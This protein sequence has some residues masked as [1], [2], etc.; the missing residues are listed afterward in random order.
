[1]TAASCPACERL[2]VSPGGSRHEISKNSVLHWIRRVI[3]RAH[4]DA[5]DLVPR[6][7]AQETKG[8]GSALLFK[9]YSVESVLRAAIWK[10]QITFSRL[11]LR[12]LVSR[13]M[14]TY[15][16]GP[17]VATQEVV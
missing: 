1:M 17:V 14:D 5:G 2:L 8:P 9:N 4:S 16:L 6:P 15:H 10:R 13:A 7:L 11:Y 12:D 3:S